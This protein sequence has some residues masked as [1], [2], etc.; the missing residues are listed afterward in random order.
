MVT[1]KANETNAETLAAIE[2]QLEKLSLDQLLDLQTNI[3]EQLR[4]RVGSKTNGNGYVVNGTV[5]APAEAATNT[6]G[7]TEP[8]DDDP[9]LQHLIDEG[10]VEPTPTEEE[11]QARR[12]QK[13]TP[14]ELAELDKV[15]LDEIAKKLPKPLTHYLLED[16]GR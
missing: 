13:Y 15:N 8:Q 11:I 9:W 14:E 10:I 5:A 6:N 3:N 2:A 4:Q 7:Q 12:H 16:R 1:D